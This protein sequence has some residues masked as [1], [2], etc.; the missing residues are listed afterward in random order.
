MQSIIAPLGKSLFC[1]NSPR[2]KD[3]KIRYTRGFSH[4]P[5][6]LFTGRKQRG[7]QRSKIEMVPSERYPAGGQNFVPEDAKLRSSGVVVVVF[8]F[9]SDMRACLKK[10]LGTRCLLMLG[11]ANHRS[12]HVIKSSDHQDGWSD[13]LRHDGESR[14][15][16]VVFFGRLFSGL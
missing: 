15:H 2:L 1:T 9:Q 4:Y 13:L 14:F 3:G 16:G 10:C 7:F 11:N 8:R 5:T 12:H 6:Y